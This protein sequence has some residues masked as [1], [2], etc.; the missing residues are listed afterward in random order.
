MY[1]TLTNALPEFKDSKIAFK[2]DTI[3]TIREGAAM[4]DNGIPELVTFIFCPPHGTWEVQETLE[5]VLEMMNGEVK[6]KKAKTAK[7]ELLN[8]D[9]K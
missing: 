5:E 1:I 9:S 6:K 7:V 4:R 2:K 3:V 8:E